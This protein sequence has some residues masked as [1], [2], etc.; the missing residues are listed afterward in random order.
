MSKKSMVPII[1]I[2]S[3]VLAVVLS[4]MTSWM[5]SSMLLSTFYS[6]LTVVFSVGMGIICSLNIGVIENED[7]YVRLFAGVL[8]VRNNSILL[9]CL[10]TIIY[11][12]TFLEM[13][14]N[15]VYCFDIYNT[16]CWFA[17]LL[18]ATTLLYFC[19]NF[20]ILQDWNFE[21][22]N[23]LRNFRKKKKSE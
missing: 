13:L 20:K 11:C 19:V 14:K 8:V 22:L 3:I 23:E 7:I 16:V 21:I 10:S 9:F 17:F 2:F 12:C 18:M 5:P 4:I 6:V 15:V 1:L